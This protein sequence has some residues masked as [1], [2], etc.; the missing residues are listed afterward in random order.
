MSSK[1]WTMWAVSI[2]PSKEAIGEAAATHV[3]KRPRQKLAARQPGIN[4]E[5]PE[6]RCSQ[7]RKYTI[8]VKTRISV[9]ENANSHD[10]APA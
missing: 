10:S 8:A 6:R 1:C 9:S 5:R 3:K 7:P 4:F 2:F